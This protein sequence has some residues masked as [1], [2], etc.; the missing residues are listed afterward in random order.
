MYNLVSKLKTAGV[1]IDCI[2]S[3]AHLITGSVPTTIQ[4]NFEKFAELDVEIA[5]TELDIRMTLPSTD[6]LLAQQAKDYTTV[7]QACMNV[8]KCVGISKRTYMRRLQETEVLT[9]GQ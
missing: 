2:G 3:Q 5:I 7:V 4:A 1:P 8:E 6:A 9:V